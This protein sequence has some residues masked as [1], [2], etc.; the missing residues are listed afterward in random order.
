[1]PLSLGNRR[2]AAL[3]IEKR[4]EIIALNTIGRICLDFK[5]TPNF[6]KKQAKELG[7]EPK[8]FQ[9]TGRKRI[10]NYLK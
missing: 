5:G 4:K 3:S 8:L 2:F 6:I 7:V 9:R 10:I 1:M